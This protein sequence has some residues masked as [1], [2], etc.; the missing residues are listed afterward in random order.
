MTKDES[1]S[2]ARLEEKVDGIANKVRQ[3]DIR[4]FG[5]E[6]TPGMILD[7]HT[8][9]NQINDLL[10]IAKKNEE[11]ISKLFLLAAP[12]WL[13]KNWKTILVVLTVFFLVIHAMIPADVSLWTLV[14]RFFTG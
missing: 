10:E 9:N 5:C 2:I 1:V 3:L 7:Q 11:N 8:Q 14:G 12:T 13:G 6:G 4:L